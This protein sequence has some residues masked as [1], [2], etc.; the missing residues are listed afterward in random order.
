MKFLSLLIAIIFLAAG[1][2]T[3]KQLDKK[4]RATLLESGEASQF[5]K[6]P[7]GTMHVR[8]LGLLNGP[9]ILL[10]HGGVVGGYAFKN[11][12]K[13]LAD[14]GFRVITPDLFGYG[15][16]DRLDED[17]TKDFYITQLTQLLAALEIKTPINMVGASSGGAI[18]TAFAAHAPQ[19]VRSIV[20]MAPAGGGKDTQPVSSVLLWPV[21][22]DFVFHF[23]G[24]STMKKQMDKAFENSPDRQN[25]AHWMGLQTRYRGYSEGVLNT[26][27]HY[28]VNWQP[29]DYQTLGKSNIPVIAIWGTEDKVNSFE[30][31][32]V[33][34]GFVP[35]LKIV[36]LQNKSHAITFEASA[37]VLTTV[38]PFVRAKSW[39]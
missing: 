15:F 29:E 20:L 16:S 22:G 39:K 26:L 18:V 37:A 33:L 31:S 1:C 17:Y 10:V 38:I 4:E 5:I 23:F 25:M 30:Q 34:Q 13:P 8:V 24:S 21:V 2:A 7:M 12:Q 11:W 6:L 36:P 9:V 19:Q 14:A 3:T 27:R 32:Q 35:Q 28:N